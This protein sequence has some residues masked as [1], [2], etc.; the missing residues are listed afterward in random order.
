LRDK[1]KYNK[2]WYDQIIDILKEIEARVET[3]PI[4]F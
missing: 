1:G 2:P 3:P 4:K